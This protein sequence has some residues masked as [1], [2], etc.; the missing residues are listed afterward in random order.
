MIWYYETIRREDAMEKIISLEEARKRISGNGVRYVSKFIW[1]GQVRYKYTLTQTIQNQ[2]HARFMQ[3]ADEVCLTGPIF[4]EERTKE[5]A[6]QK[7]IS[8]FQNEHPNIANFYLDAP[9]SGEKPPYQ[10]VISKTKTQ[11]KSV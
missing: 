5:S 11:K 9:S 10:V 7:I 6:K 4:V 3:Y 2:Q 8:I 1:W